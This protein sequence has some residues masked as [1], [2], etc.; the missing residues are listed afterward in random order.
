MRE[1]RNR[2]WQPGQPGEQKEQTYKQ[3]EEAG[4]KSEEEGKREQQV[5][6]NSMLTAALCVQPIGNKTLQLR[7]K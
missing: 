5:R 2:G 6:Q 3:P 1:T 7:G 4:H